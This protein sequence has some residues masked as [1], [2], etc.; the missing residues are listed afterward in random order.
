MGRINLG[1]LLCDGV[2]YVELS[3][4]VVKG[5]LYIKESS[6][7]E[8]GDVFKIP[9]II[10]DDKKR[11]IIPGWMRKRLNTKDFGVAFDA[12]YLVLIPL[13]EDDLFEEKAE[14]KKGLPKNY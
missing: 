8:R 2:K 12:P 3:Y 9:N 1:K 13:N 4:R 11:I 10:V 14:S 6:E 7:S 5:H